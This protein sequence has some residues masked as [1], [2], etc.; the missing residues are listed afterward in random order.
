[1]DLKIKR[2]VSDEDQKDKWMINIKLSM[3]CRG[4]KN[5][6]FDV[7]IRFSNKNYLQRLF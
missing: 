6:R 3:Y 2:F 5:E 7:S 1:M 4:E